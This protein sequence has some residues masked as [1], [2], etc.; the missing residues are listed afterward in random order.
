MWVV[1][2]QLQRFLN[3]I[4]YLDSFSS[5]LWTGLWTETAFVDPLD[6]LKGRLLVRV[7]L[8]V[9]LFN[10]SVAF[11]NSEQGSSG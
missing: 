10:F 2:A 11:D 8:L 6:D 9:L 3:G 5:G 4:D 7:T 1:V